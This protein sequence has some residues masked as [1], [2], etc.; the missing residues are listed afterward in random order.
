MMRFKDTVALMTSS[1]WFDSQIILD[2]I[3][4]WVEIETPTDVPAQVDRLTS[5][6]AD[7]HRDLPVTLERI[8]GTDGC[9]DHL[10]ARSAWGQDAPGILVLSHLDTVH[11]MGFIE[12]Q[13]L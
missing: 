13:C 9:G 6:V 5:L 7:Q 2:G 4:R 3:R 1:N 10:V 8:P 11:P 12:L